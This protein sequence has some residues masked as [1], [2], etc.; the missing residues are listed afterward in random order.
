MKKLPVIL[1]VAMA[2]LTLSACEKDLEQVESSAPQVA[3]ASSLAKPALLAAG[4]WHQTG[5]TV[6]TAA[7]GTDE[8]VSSDLFDHVKP[9][10]LVVAANY[11]ADGSYTLVRG[12]AA[13][14]AVA[15]PINGT[16][17]LNAAADSLIVT[18]AQDTKRLAVSELSANT[19]RLTYTQAEEGRKPTTYTTVFSH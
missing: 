12:A 2:A 14:G 11:Q 17:R 10:M 8:A 9:S 7:E 4:T 18:Q 3:A 1:G 19:M 5:L 6:S 16:W 15:E 13:S